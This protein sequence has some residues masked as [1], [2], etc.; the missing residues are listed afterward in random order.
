[1]G[2]AGK[3]ATIIIDKYSKAHMPF[4]HTLITCVDLLNYVLNTVPW[5]VKILS[6]MLSK[7]TNFFKSPSYRYKTSSQN[8]S[9]HLI[10]HV[11]ISMWEMHRSRADRNS[12]FEQYE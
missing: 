6:V 3:T 7:K 1:M 5:P 9:R 8:I 11:F 10:F 4:K 12:L 2:S